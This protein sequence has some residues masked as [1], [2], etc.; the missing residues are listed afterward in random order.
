MTLQWFEYDFPEVEKRYRLYVDGNETPWFI[1][2]A[3]HRAHYTYGEKYG[4]Y[5]AGTSEFGTASCFGAFKTLKAA[6]EA[7]IAKARNG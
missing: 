2:G 4:L 5:G 6:R 3:Y 7:A 1:T